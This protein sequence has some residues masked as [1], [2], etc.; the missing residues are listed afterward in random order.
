MGQDPTTYEAWSGPIC[1]Y[2]LNCTIFDQLLLR[3]I[4]T[5]VAA[6]CKILRLKYIKFN[7]DC[8]SA[9]DSIGRDYCS[10]LH[11]PYTEGKEP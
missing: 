9:A 10:V 11:T 1:L 2:C 3:E 4:I 7:F 5:I 8:S 6:R